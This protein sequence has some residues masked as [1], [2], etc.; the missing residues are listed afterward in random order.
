MARQNDN[1]EERLERLG[2]GEHRAQ[3]DSKVRSLITDGVATIVPRKVESEEQVARLLSLMEDLA[4]RMDVLDRKNRNIAEEMRV[5]ERRERRRRLSIGLVAAVLAW[6]T[7]GAW[8]K[9]RIDAPA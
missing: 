4:K 3:F 7:V 9:T 6:L 1:F 2:S 5:R 8:I